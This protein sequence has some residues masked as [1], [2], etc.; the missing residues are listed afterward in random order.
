M[1]HALIYLSQLTHPLDKEDVIEI[2]TKAAV[3]NKKT[4]I[5]GFLTARNNQFVQYLEGEKEPLAK[6]MAIIAADARHD[7]LHTIHLIPAVPQFA[8]WSMRYISSED[9]T[10]AT[11][12]DRLI[13]TIQH[14]S[15]ADYDQ[16]LIEAQVYTIINRISR[17][18]YLPKLR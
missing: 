1:T 12:D 2:A 13:S 10:R 9:A 5:T 4:G 15:S 7:V 16:K 14:I 3:K 8:N 18:L 6:L 17:I 11:M